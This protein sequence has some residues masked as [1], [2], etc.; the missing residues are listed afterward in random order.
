[1]ERACKEPLAHNR[2]KVACS[3]GPSERDGRNM[4]RNTTQKYTPAHAQIISDP[5]I[6]PL[7]VVAYQSSRHHLLAI[8]KKEIEI[9][10]H[11]QKNSRSTY[12]EGCGKTPPTGPPAN[13]NS[14]ARLEPHRAFLTETARF[15]RP[16]TGARVPAP[17]TKTSQPRLSTHAYDNP[18]P[19]GPPCV[20]H[21]GRQQ[22]PKDTTVGEKTSKISAGNGG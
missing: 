11:T 20:A 22:D 18:P 8:I 7:N 12:D 21:L 5:R 19:I 2:Q 9:Q 16:P 17:P 10:S 15:C 1:M 14:S 13:S 6:S 3:P 4:K